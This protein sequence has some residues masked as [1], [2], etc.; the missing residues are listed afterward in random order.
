MQQISFELPAMYGD[1]HV[2]AVRR[3]LTQLS[4]V[5]DVYASS[6]FQMVEVTFDQAQVGPEAIEQTLAAAGYLGDLPSP[7]EQT[8]QDGQKPFMR[9]TV[10]YAQTGQIVGFAQKAPYAGR[11]LWP[12]PG[13]GPMPPHTKT[14]EE[15][16]GG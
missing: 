3:L 10:A 8:S 12:C 2:I 4:G 13:I 6:G 7:I 11:P 16:S 15:V 1:H 14:E 5:S 9:H